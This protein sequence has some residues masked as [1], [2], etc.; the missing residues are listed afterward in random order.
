MM[1]GT[2]LFGLLNVSQADLEFAFGSG[3]SPLVFSV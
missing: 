1:L 3:S 2:H